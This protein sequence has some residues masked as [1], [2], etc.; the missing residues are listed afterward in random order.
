MV[1]CG[2]VIQF[3]NIRKDS[4]IKEWQRKWDELMFRR[5]KSTRSEYTQTDSQLEY[6]Q[7]DRSHDSR[8]LSQRSPEKYRR[9]D[10][11]GSS[12][13]KDNNYKS[14]AAGKDQ[15]YKALSSERDERYKALSSGK[16]PRYKASSAEKEQKFKGSYRDERPRN[17]YPDVIRQND[18]PRESQSSYK[19]SR[20]KSPRRMDEKRR[21]NDDHPS[22]HAEPK[23]ELDLRLSLL[24]KR[25]NRSSP[26]KLKADPDVK[27]DPQLK[28]T[29]PRKRKLAQSPGKSPI[30]VLS[31]KSSDSEVE[32]IQTAKHPKVPVMIDSKTVPLEK[33]KDGKIGQKVETNL[34]VNEVAAMGVKKGMEAEKIILDEETTSFHSADDGSSKSPRLN[35][36]EKEISAAEK[37]ILGK[38]GEDMKLERNSVTNSKLPIDEAESTRVKLPLDEVILEGLKE[39][40]KAEAAAVASTPQQFEPDVKIIVTPTVAEPSP[41]GVTEAEESPTVK[42]RTSTATAVVIAKSPVPDTVQKSSPAKPTKSSPIEA[43]ASPPVPEVNGN[44]LPST[45]NPPEPDQPLQ[46]S[47]LSLNGTLDSSG[48]SKENSLNK[49]H[50]KKKSCRTYEKEVLEDGTVVFTISRKTKKKKKD[51]TKT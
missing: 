36:L 35:D 10:D 47:L 15:R 48:A 27:I 33:P 5:N 28:A 39:V 8:R 31:I 46:D 20:S 40:R 21:K 32:I 49:S 34:A 26:R 23:K 38:E 7:R 44:E 25:A 19:R 29:S 24:K 22:K 1:S 16:D 51:K 13:E 50:K 14:S 43:K 9:Y 12:S 37:F 18:R 17:H 41:A 6:R 45:G 2:M 42:R 30:E 4:T 11:K 3:C